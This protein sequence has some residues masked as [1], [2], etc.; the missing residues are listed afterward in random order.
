M[1]EQFE[2]KRNFFYIYINQNTI[3]SETTDVYIP[4]QYQKTWDFLSFDYIISNN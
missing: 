4:K 2:K 1:I 3:I